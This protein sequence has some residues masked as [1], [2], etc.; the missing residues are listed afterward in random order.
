MEKKFVNIGGRE[1][2]VLS[3]STLIGSWEEINNIPAS[4]ITKNDKDTERLSGML[5]RGYE[6]KFG[7]VNENGEKYEKDC[8]DDFVNRYFVERGLNMP[9]DIQH[10]DDIEHLAGRVIYVEVNATGFYFIAYIPRTYIHYNELRDLISNGIIQG[11]SKMGWATD[12]EFKYKADGTFDYELIKQMQIISM[13]LVTTPANGIA[14]EK[15]QEIKNG[16]TFVNKTIEQQQDN[17]KSD[18]LE[19]MFNN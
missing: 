16:R 13:S 19:A 10:R 12:W 18:P 9:V 7:R 3:D 8:L 6:T 14:F 15:V 17:A 11:F 4:T 1:C 5:I 2:P